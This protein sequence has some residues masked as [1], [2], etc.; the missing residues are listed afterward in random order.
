MMQ[1]RQVLVPGTDAINIQDRTEI[2]ALAVLKFIPNLEVIPKLFGGF[3][4]GTK[5]T[6]SDD[7]GSGLLHF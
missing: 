2:K 5:S 7:I 3:Y 6:R 4:Y 1:T